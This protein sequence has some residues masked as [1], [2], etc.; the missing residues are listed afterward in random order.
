MRETTAILAFLLLLV[1]PMTLAQEPE[2]TVNESDYDTSPPAADESYLDEAENETSAEPTLQ[3][4][5]FDTAPPP[6]DESYLDEAEREMGSSG[7][8]R[9][10]E[11][12]TPAA[13]LLA[14]VA[15]LGV[16]ALVWRR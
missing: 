3:E 7:P 11:A 12:A 9:D 15:S 14:L 2:P 16:A 1:T 8:A 4:G 6:A 13:P 5:D 10:G